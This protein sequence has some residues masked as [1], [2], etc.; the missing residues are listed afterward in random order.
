M[1]IDIVKVENETMGEE[2]LYCIYGGALA[3]AGDPWLFEQ[4]VLVM[5]NS[6]CFYHVTLCSERKQNPVG[7]EKGDPPDRIFC[8]PE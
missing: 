6:C 5:A 2:G 8:V 7:V 3:E 1:K 4:S